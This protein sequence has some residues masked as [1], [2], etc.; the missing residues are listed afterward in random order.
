MKQT[1]TWVRSVKC[2]GP[3]HRGAE[4]CA[5]WRCQRRTALPCKGTSIDSPWMR[6]KLEGRR[7]FY[8]LWGPFHLSPERSHNKICCVW[9]VSLWSGSVSHE[10]CILCWRSTD[11]CMAARSHVWASVAAIEAPKPL[12]GIQAV[13]SP[14]PVIWN[15]SSSISTWLLTSH[16]SNSRIIFITHLPQSTT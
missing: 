7:W 4:Y 10:L 9:W 1:K 11:H 5:G 14:S 6:M 13:I 16:I 12:A 2:A 3:R 15:N 8:A